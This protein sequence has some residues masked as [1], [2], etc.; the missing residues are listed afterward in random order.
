MKKRKI[1]WVVC[2]LIAITVTG[3]SQ[4]IKIENG[5]A[6]STLT[7]K[8]NSADDNIYPYQASLGVDYMDREWYALSSQIGFLRKGIG[9]ILETILDKGSTTEE[10]Q[11]QL[12]YITMNTTF[13][14]K[15]SPWN[16]FTAYLGA[17][18]RIDIYTG[19]RS[20][21][22]FSDTKVSGTHKLIAG[23]KT[24]AGF[25]GQYNRLQ[26]G[27]NFGYLPSFVKPFGGNNTFS[28]DRTFT[29]GFVLGYVL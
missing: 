4:V 12:D 18:P 15:T 25:Y 23:L 29:L 26:A 7:N 14:I 13:R 19:G 9:G 27:I 20:T 21:S 8:F 1:L 16:N 17:G 6:I 11:I 5:F 22:N 3:T 24:E 2:L 10:L 28:G